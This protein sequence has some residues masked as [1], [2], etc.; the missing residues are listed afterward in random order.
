MFGSDQIERKYPKDS[1][2]L[3]DPPSQS[4]SQDPTNPLD[5]QDTA[6]PRDLLD[7]KD[8]PDAPDPPG[9]RDPSEHPEKILRATYFTRQNTW[10]KV[11]FFRFEP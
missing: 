9:P 1:P 5:P 6:D 7:P 4:D 11:A 10:G 2:G 3:R 8:R